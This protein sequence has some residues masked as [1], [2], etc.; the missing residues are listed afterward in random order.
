MFYSRFVNS[1]DT[2]VIKVKINILIFWN[3]DNH[4]YV[5]GLLNNKYRE[6]WKNNVFSLK[7]DE[8]EVAGNIKM[9]NW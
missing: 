9:T 6:N 8:T 2:L 5:D 7:K 3:G 4:L 1:N